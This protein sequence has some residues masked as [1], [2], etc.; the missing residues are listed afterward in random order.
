[1]FAQLMCIFFEPDNAHKRFNT[2]DNIFG[3]SLKNISGLSALDT[4]IYIV[5][6]ASIVATIGLP[7]Y[8]I[9]NAQWNI[10]FLIF[11][12]I[13]LASVIFTQVKQSHS[14]K[15][16]ELK[17]KLSRSGSI[18]AAIVAILFANDEALRYPFLFKLILFAAVIQVVLFS[19]Y[20]LFQEIKAKKEVKSATTPNYRKRSYIQL[21]LL[22]SAILIGIAK[23]SHNFGKH[24]NLSDNNIEDYYQPRADNLDKVDKSVTKTLDKILEGS[25]AEAQTEEQVLR[26]KYANILSF[27]EVTSRYNRINYS[28]LSIWLITIIIWIYVLFFKKETLLT[29]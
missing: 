20:L 1:M 2:M 16:Y 6:I 18:V 10:L 28:L 17:V 12:V 26:D 19:I 24:L 15:N 23:N 3:D 27:D 21:A 9:T 11:I 29:E 25:K 8:E 7:N 13:L 22:T 5:G 14:T 4:P